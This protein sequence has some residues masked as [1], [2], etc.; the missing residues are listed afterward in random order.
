MTHFEVIPAIDLLEGR[1]V[2]LSQGR[3]EEAT[4]YDEDPAAVA[5]RF[6]A[7]GIPR[8][9]VVDL[10]GARSGRPAP[11]GPATSRRCGRWWPAAATCR[12]SSAAASAPWPPSRRASPWAWTA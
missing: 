2:R 4:V 10:D 9:H 5:A 1:C 3:Y 11:V 6:V 7:L 8:L 12:C